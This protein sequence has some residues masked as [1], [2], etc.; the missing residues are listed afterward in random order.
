MHLARHQIMLVATFAI[1]VASVFP[2]VAGTA[3]VISGGDTGVLFEHLNV[4]TSDF[5]P[6]DDAIVTINGIDIPFLSGSRYSGVLDES[7]EAGDSFT[8]VVEIGL[9]TVTCTDV[10][11]PAPFITL[12]LDGASIAEGAPLLVE[13]TSDSDPDRFSISAHPCDTS[14]RETVDGTVR[15]V[16]LDSSEFSTTEPVRISVYAYQEGNFSGPADPASNLNLR[17]GGTPSFI[18]VIPATPTSSAS[19]SAVKAWFGR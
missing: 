16:E 7:L 14:C 19:W 3:Y 4:W 17:H 9:D 8:L 15:S 13:W 12:P 11:P 6:I 18:T 5:D 1:V 2:A 10:V